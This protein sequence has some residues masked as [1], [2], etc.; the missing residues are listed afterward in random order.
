MINT[1][2]NKWGWT[3][4]KAVEVI[5]TNAFGNVIFKSDKGAYWRI[6][7]EELYCEKIAENFSE[8]EP[9]VKSEYFIAGWEI[10]ELVE[11]ATAYLGALNEDE[12][13]CLKLP[14]VLGGLPD[15]EN[16]GKISHL[17]LL[18]FSGEM[19]QHIKDLPDGTKF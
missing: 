2:N 10:P 9:L 14:S 16:L 12:K 4:A 11:T 18:S 5:D 1:I 15:L 19:A 8:F 7:P 13:F 3:G 6:C 17:Q